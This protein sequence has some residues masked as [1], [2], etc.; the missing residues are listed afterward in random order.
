MARR[1]TIYLDPALHRALKLKS[2]A[3]DRSV[4]DLVNEAVRVALLED[5][6]D[7]EALT[8]R[9]SEPNLDFESAVRSLRSRGRL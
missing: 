4:S 7:L 9:S 8:E 6:E 3:A 2:I 1:S 5:A